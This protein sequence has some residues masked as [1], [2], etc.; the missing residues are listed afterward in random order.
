[1]AASNPLFA[2]VKPGDLCCPKCGAPESHPNGKWILIR[3][4]K[5]YDAD[6]TSWS[7]CLV[8]AGYYTRFLAVVPEFLRPKNWQERGWFSMR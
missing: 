6:G 5:V 8:C 3:F 2:S 7:Q 4:F 1:M